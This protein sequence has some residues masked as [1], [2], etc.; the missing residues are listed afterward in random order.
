[1]YNIN[2]KQVKNG[3]F[4]TV[5]KSNVSSQGPATSFESIMTNVA[6]SITKAQEIDAMLDGIKNNSNNLGEFIFNT[7]EELIAF[8]TILGDDIN[9]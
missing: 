5:S 8:L 2:I 3:F 4:L 1:M 7:Y 6:S 9:K